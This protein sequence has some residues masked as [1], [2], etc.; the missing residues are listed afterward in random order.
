MRA[1]RAVEFRHLVADHQPHLVVALRALRLHAVAAHQSDQA[2]AIQVLKIGLGAAA[3][4]A[5][6]LTQ[7]RFHLEN[8]DAVVLCPVLRLRVPALDEFGL[9]SASPHLL[10]VGAGVFDHDAVLENQSIALGRKS[11]LHVYSLK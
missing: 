6:N 9:E 5:A 4:L 11:G 8:A 2:D 3:Q 7:L 1:Q 10:Q